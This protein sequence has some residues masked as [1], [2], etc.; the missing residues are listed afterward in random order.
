MSGAPQLVSRLR[1]NEAKKLT[2]KNDLAL[3]A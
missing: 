3:A 1:K 2:A